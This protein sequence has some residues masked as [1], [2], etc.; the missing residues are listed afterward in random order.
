MYIQILC[1]YVDNLSGPF[2]VVYGQSAGVAGQSTRII[3]I[4]LQ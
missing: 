4:L 1:G 3:E 2:S